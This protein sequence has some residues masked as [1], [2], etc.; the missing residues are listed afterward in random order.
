MKEKGYKTIAFPALGTGNLCFPY[1]SV[2]K[3]IKEALTEHGTQH[4]STGVETVYIILHETEEQCI[5]VI[6]VYSI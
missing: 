4:P 5:Q 6:L 3:A 1:I 2:A